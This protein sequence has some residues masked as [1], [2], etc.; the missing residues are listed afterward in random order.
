[1]T[2]NKVELEEETK[3]W[4][5]VQDQ[6]CDGSYAMVSHTADFKISERCATEE[7]G[8]QELKSW[9]DDPTY[10]LRLV[11]VTEVKRREVEVLKRVG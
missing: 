7:E 11:R 5:E 4:Y 6:R 9:G 8:L 3:S 2:R 1:M 10:Y